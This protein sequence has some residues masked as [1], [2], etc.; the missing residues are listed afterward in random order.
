MELSS[1]S[2]ADIYTQ[3]AIADQTSTNIEKLRETA[4]KTSNAKSDEELMGAC[5]EFEA[6]FLEQVFKEM[7]KTVDIFSKDENKDQSTSNLVDFF[8]GNT[9]QD[10]CKQ[11]TKTQGL[12]LAQM[13]YENMKRNYEIPEADASATES[14]SLYES[15]Q[16]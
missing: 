9:L 13:L 5:V 1:I 14:A 8:K 7:Q 16:S 3:R 11:S 4:R 2:G 6:Y 15:S 12:G 10:F